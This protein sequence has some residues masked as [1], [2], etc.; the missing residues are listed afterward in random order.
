MDAGFQV[1]AKYRVEVL[2]VG[3]LI[4]RRITNEDTEQGIPEDRENLSQ[5][6][7]KG[8]TDL[9]LRF[10]GKVLS[11]VTDTWVT[12]TGPGTHSNWRRNS[13]NC[14]CR[15]ASSSRKATTSPSSLAMRSF[16]AWTTSR[17]GSG[18]AAGVSST[19]TAPHSR[20]A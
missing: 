7:Q 18:A 16:S 9:C 15:R 17:A 10:A 11:H 3:T 20:W 1:A 14:A 19:V 5:Q 8:N 6:I 2:D 4:L 12:E 13:A